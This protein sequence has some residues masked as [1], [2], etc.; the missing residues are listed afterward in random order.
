MISH[1]L[2]GRVVIATRHHRLEELT[3][4][5]LLVLIIL[6]SYADSATHVCWPNQT[7]LARCCRM[8]RYSVM[9]ALKG[10]E[11]KGFIQ[12][13]QR[14]QEG[15]GKASKLYKILVYPFGPEAV[16]ASVTVTRETRTPKTTY[17][18]LTDNTWEQRIR[19]EF[20]SDDERALDLLLDENPYEVTTA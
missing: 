1:D 13:W 12:S 19:N 5:E 2:I 8:S 16:Q 20:P 4:S 15:K 9:P 6:S 11:S 17:Q 14:T 3:S 7:E 18:K 10:L